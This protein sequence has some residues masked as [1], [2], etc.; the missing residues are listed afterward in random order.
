MARNT[1]VHDMF[2]VVAIFVAA[3][4]LSFSIPMQIRAQEHSDELFKTKCTVC[5][6]ANGDGNTA[7][8]KGLKMRD[9]RSGEVQKRA[10]SQLTT[11]LHCGKGKMPGYEGKLS[12]EQIAQLVSYVR[13][14]A[15][16]R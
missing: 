14:L 6:G 3:M 4:V 12:D 8:G 1:L 16:G 9:L 5:H 11:I 2:R 13:S 15:A 10:D 7:A